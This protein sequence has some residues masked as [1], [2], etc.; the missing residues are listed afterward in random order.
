MTTFLILLGLSLFI[1]RSQLLRVALAESGQGNGASGGK[2]DVSSLHASPL[3]GAASGWLSLGGAVLLM[4]LALVQQGYLWGIGLVIAG[5][6]GG[7]LLSS[8]LLPT[9]GSTLALGHHGG[10]GNKSIAE[11][12]RRYGAI[13]AFSVAGVALLAWGL[14]IR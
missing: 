2:I 10:E 7:V 8:F 5:V 12:N 13:I 4:L 11:F 3:M 14:H 6:A 9:I 1:L